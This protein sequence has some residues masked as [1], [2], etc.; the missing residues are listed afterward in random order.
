VSKRGSP[1]PGRY[2]PIHDKPGLRQVLERTIKERGFEGAPSRAA[3]ELGVDQSLLSRLLHEQSDHIS[4]K[5]FA[6]LIGFVLDEEQLPHTDSASNERYNS[7]LLTIQPVELSTLVGS[8]ARWYGATMRA[9]SEGT[10]IRW[11]RT[12]RGFEAR[13][14]IDSDGGGS[15]RDRERDALWKFVCARFPATEAEAE[16]LFAALPSDA[17]GYAR[18]IKIRVLD[19][20]LNSSESGFVELSWRELKDNEPE[21]IEKVVSLGLRRERELLRRTLVPERWKQ[22]VTPTLEEF[23]ARHGAECVEL[24]EDSQVPESGSV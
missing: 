13:D 18:I 11:V 1:P 17:I 6:D 16:R 3:S 24:D 12:A 20:L 5:N 23:A 21:T 10:G 4:Q 19:V 15:F 22:I 2:W 7:L 9:A 8:E 14:I